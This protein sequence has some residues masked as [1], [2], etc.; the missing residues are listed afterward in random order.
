MRHPFQATMRRPTG[1]GKGLALDFDQFG[2]AIC[3]FS[4][5]STFSGDRLILM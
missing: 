2:E 5:S 3:G 4:C 1:P